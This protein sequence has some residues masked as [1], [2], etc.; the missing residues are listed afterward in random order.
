MAVKKFVTEN[1]IWKNIFTGRSVRKGSVEEVL[2]RVP[3]FSILTPR[4]LK[5][6]AAIVH[7]RE[8]RVGEPV[9]YQGDPGLG[10]YI[11][12]E[13]EVSISIGDK[14]GQQRELVNLTEGDFF[15]ELA[16]LDESP[17]SANAVCKVDCTL[18]GFFRP[19]L[20]DLIEKKSSLGIKIVLKLAEIVAMRLRNTDR[21]LSKLKSKLDQIQETNG[22]SDVQREVK[23]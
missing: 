8:Y 2:S 15:G 17:R 10:M 4:E 6:V 1:P 5:E 13:G 14:D 12:Q 21:E 22:G 7:K 20:F 3:A 19:D 16:L 18:I 11:V 23:A 9:F